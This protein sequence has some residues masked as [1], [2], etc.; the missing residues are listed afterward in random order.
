MLLL[1][2]LGGMM[3]THYL[4]TVV[5]FVGIVGLVLSGHRRH[6]EQIR[7]QKDSGFQEVARSGSGIPLW[8][9]TR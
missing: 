3:E 6:G 9:W 7:D 4:L 2:Y 8:A 5:L 1:Q